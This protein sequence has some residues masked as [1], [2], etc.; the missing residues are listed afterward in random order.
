MA[1]PP[2]FSE[3]ESKRSNKLIRWVFVGIN[4]F[5]MKLL[6]NPLSQNSSQRMAVYTDLRLRTALAVPQLHPSSPNDYARERAQ[7]LSKNQ[8]WNFCC[9]K[10]GMASLLLSCL[11]V[12]TLHQSCTF[13]DWS[14]GVA[15]A[16]DRTL[17]QALLVRN[18]HST[19]TSF[20]IL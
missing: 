8:L 3:T 13:W 15:Q 5:N 1:F 10:S 18:N 16:T 7:H 19:S 20:Y 11:S 17:F 4:F 14:Q 9:W 2:G 6:Y 12:T